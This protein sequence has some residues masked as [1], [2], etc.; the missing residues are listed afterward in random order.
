[1]IRNR[2]NC[3]KETLNK[4][5]KTYSWIPNEE[6][7]RPSPED[8][9]RKKDL[10]ENI[11]KSW[12]S[13]KD[14]ILH[15]I[16]NESKTS[17]QFFNF[18]L[19]YDSDKWIFSECIF[20]YNLPKYANHYILWFSGQNYYYNFDDE[21]INKKIE[22]NLFEKLGY[23]NFDFAWYKN[24]KPSVPEFYHIQVFWISL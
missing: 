24:P 12:L 9:S 6:S 14:Y 1:M 16:F 15:T 13:T 17:N 20:R 23:N 8:I 18:V 10:I 4:L 11:N 7:I 19:R 3:D 2:I 5:N 22:E 21:I